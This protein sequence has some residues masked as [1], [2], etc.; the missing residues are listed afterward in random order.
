[1]QKDSA[2]EKIFDVGVGQFTLQAT[3]FIPKGAQVGK[4]KS[5]ISKEN[6]HTCNPKK[7]KNIQITINYGF[8]ENFE[9]LNAQGVVQNYDELDGLVLVVAQPADVEVTRALEKLGISK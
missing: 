5:D 9:S 4:F 3:T 2:I 1:M 8:T 6:V 7:K